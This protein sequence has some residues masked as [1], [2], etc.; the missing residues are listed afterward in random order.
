M[1]KTL[2]QLL[3]IFLAGLFLL[4]CGRSGLKIP[5]SSGA[6]VKAKAVFVYDLKKDKLLLMKGAKKVQPASLTKLLTL[7]TGEDV[8]KDDAVITAGDELQK[9]QPHSSLAWIRRGMK[10]NTD[11]LR[12]GMLLPSGN[13]AAYIYAAAAGRALLKKEGKSGGTEEALRRFCQ[14]MNDKAAEI[15]MKKSHFVNPDGYKEKGLTTTPGDMLL[16]SREFLRHKIYQKITALPSADVRYVS[17]ETNHYVNSNKLLQKNSPY[18][19][20]GI[21]GVKTGSL[22]EYCCLIAHYQ[23]EG[24]DLLVGVFGSP[25]DAD[26]YKDTL[27]L[28]RSFGAPLH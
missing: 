11:T 10:V 2:R 13:D 28:L 17:G 21:V 26:R 4:S 23:K 12:K 25:T 6:V 3:L 27:T 22:P 15:G 16:L 18:Y 5:S 8:L 9:V 7:I 19:T 20:P 1:K 24:T 14:A